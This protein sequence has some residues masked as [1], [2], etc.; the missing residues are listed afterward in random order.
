[1]AQQKDHVLLMLAEASGRDRLTTLAGLRASRQWSTSTHFD[2]DRLVP[3]SILRTTSPLLVLDRSASLMIHAYVSSSKRTLRL[4]ERTTEALNGG[5]PRSD[6]LV[7]VR[8]RSK[9][10]AM[11]AG[12]GSAITSRTCR[13][14][15]AGGTVCASSW[16]GRSRT[17]GGSRRS[18]RT[19]QASWPSTDAF[20]PQTVTP[21]PHQP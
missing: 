21:Q 19:L 6:S 16:R 2:V 4:R 7:P 1:M 11:S 5:R 14:K 10:R 13:W 17:G 15:S 9:S 8:F 20:Q 18:S 3:S 12:D